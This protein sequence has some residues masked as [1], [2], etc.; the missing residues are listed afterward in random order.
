MPLRDL[1]AQVQEAQQQAIAAPAETPDLDLS[2]EV[3]A[4]PPPEVDAEPA[5]PAAEADGGGA[6]AEAEPRILAGRGGRRDGRRGP[7][8]RPSPRGRPERRRGGAGG[9]VGRGAAGLPGDSDERRRRR[10]AGL[11]GRPMGRP[12]TI[13]LT[14]GIAAGKSEALAAFERLGAATI[15][16]DAV[17][18]E[19][20]DSR[21]AARRGW[22]SAGARRSRRTGRV[23][24]RRV[25]EIVFADPEELAWLESRDPPAGRRADRR[26]AR[27]RC[28]PGR[29]SPWSRCRCCSRAAMEDVFDA[30]VAVV[31][32]DEV[33]RERAAAPR[34]RA[35]STSARRASSTRTRRPRAPTTWSATTARSRTSRSS[36]PR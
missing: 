26:L 20:L 8:R 18:H 11:S 25:G 21:A 6:E 22:S 23:D 12:L 35:A 3:F 31:A 1:G 14:G 19:L 27:A 30:T 10:R 34:P 29:R 17:V 36:C 5:E 16:S 32:A 4:E 2:E 28:P 13:G 33:R 7:P 15:S 9:R 24:R